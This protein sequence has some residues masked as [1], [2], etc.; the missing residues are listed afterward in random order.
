MKLKSNIVLTLVFLT[1]M[2]ACGGGGISKEVLTGSKWKID[3]AALETEVDALLEKVEDEE[4]KTQFETMKPMMKG[5]LEA[6]VIE[7]KEDGTLAAEGLPGGQDEA[8][9]KWSLDGSTLALEMD[10]GKINF[11]AAGSAESMTLKL[12]KEELKRS[13]EASGDPMPEDMEKS[14]EGIDAITITLKPAE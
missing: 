2:T 11:E 14:L 3:V 10:E 9:P 4:A 5:M 7:F 1:L 13:A 8:G 6:V 12:T